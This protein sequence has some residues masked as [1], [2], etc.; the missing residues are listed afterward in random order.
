[1]G[2]SI[3]YSGRFNTN[4]ALSEMIEEVKDIAEVYGW[5]STVFEENF[6]LIPSDKT[7]HDKNIYGMIFTPPGCE[8]ISLCFLSNGR[9]SSPINLLA[10]GNSTNKKEK[11][12]L[13]MVSVKTQFAGSS[14]HKIIIHLLKY[15]SD[16]YFKEFTLTDEGQYWETG[17]EKLLDENFDRYNMLMD[18]VSDLFENNP[19]NSGESFEKYFTRILKQIKNKRKK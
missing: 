12:Y 4:A 10:F 8:P 3:H 5:D 15:L 7:T 1:M 19:I 9:M 16:K 18:M 11:A 6:P 14:I 17:D 2:L 13:Y